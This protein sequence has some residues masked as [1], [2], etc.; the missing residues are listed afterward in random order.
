MDQRDREKDLRE[1]SQMIVDALA[2]NEAIMSHLAELKERGIIDSSTLLGLALRVNELLELSA[3]MF[4]Q[5]DT[6]IET[7]RALPQPEHG[8]VRA[9]GAAPGSR[10]IYDGREITATEAAFEEWVIERFDEQEWLRKIGL[11]W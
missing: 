8:M 6:R 2:R 10:A 11:S 1:L 9:R 4:A 7:P 3:T 5:Q